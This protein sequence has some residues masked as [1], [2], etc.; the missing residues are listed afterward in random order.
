MIIDGSNISSLRSELMKH[1]ILALN[2]SVERYFGAEA[3]RRN[4]T[5][6]NFSNRS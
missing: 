4:V 2:V 3:L 1:D 6:L 5:K